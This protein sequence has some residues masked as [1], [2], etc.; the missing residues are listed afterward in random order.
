MVVYINHLESTMRSGRERTEGPDAERLRRNCSGEICSMR[1]EYRLGCC[2]VLRL[3]WR[4]RAL[5]DTE[6]MVD[7]FGAMFEQVIGMTAM[8]EIYMKMS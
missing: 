7:R 4:S 2:R 3:E 5:R 6:F 1:S 8:V